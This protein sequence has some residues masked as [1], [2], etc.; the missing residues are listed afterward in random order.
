M[1]GITEIS[2]ALAAQ[3]QS[4]AEHLLPGG[5][6]DGHEWRAGA[7]NGEAGQS[8]GVHLSGNKAGVWSDFASGESGDLLD[9]WRATRGGTLGEALNEA[10]EWLGMERPK[11]YREPARNYVKPP[12]PKCTA[13]DDTAALAYMT[14]DRNLPLGVLQRYKVAAA[15]N[16][17]IF[18][19]LKPDG[20]LAMAK[21]REARDGGRTQPTAKDCEPILFGWQAIPD[22]ARE[23]V[24]TEGEIDAL[25]MAAYGFP[26]MSV[27][28]GGG[29]GAK[30]QWIESDFERLD[31][32]ERIYL[33]LDMDRVGEEAAEE[34]AIR[35]GRHRCLRVE[36][37][38][39]DA[40]ECLVN[41]V[42]D[43]DMLAAV[44][45]AKSLDPEGLR[46]PSELN[47]DVIRLFWPKEGEHV[48]YRMPLG[49]L[50]G[51]KLMFRP[52]E[53]TLW[54]GES[55]VGKSQ[56]LSDAVVDWIGQ[57]SR[58]CLAS[59][60][61][62][63]GQTLKRM[64][65]QIIGVDRPTDKAINL[66]LQWADQG[67]L[68][69]DRVGKV[70]VTGMLEIFDYA[71]AK[72]GCNQ[73]VIDSFM[74]LGIAGDDYTAQER[75]VFE[76]VTW[77][78]DRNV[79]VHLVAHSRKGSRDRMGP[80]ETE[81]VKGAMEVGA[82]AFNI[83]AVWR[84]RRLEEDIEAAETEEKREALAEKPGVILRVA[85]QRNGD[86]EGRVGLWFDQKTY[87]YYSSHDNR[88]WSRGYPIQDEEQSQAAA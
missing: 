1:A 80:A 21:F 88:T 23:V 17:I 3:A 34:I 43:R 19:F 77:A 16:S 27:P 30:Q 86:F 37:P 63:G 31:R 59:L 5:R 47:D 49:K 44:G 25:S 15:G 40:N 4:V 7:V 73:F 50:G 58:T 76:I 82:N 14:E 42:A 36:L 24:I 75:A 71:R 20:E 62:K 53:L 8:L 68:L 70:S 38:C 41:G 45:G 69:Y 26:A 55:G 64:C 2:R 84:N 22:D 13:L 33:A 56:I 51:G 87:R 83:I 35:L 54:T 18:P 61:M 28:F 60:E 85:K 65:K 67:L 39:K 6:K 72:Y 66:A 74:R 78:I 29:K 12:K 57:G 46:R 79:H 11:P 9:L 48:G 32:F 52:A 81:D 10:R